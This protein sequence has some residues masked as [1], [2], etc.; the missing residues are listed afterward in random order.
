[1]SI[2]NGLYESGELKETISYFEERLKG[3]RERFSIYSLKMWG[4]THEGA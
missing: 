3:I 2:L 1:L 4:W